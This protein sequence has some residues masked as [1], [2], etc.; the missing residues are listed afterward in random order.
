MHHQLT[1]HETVGGIQIQ[2]I[3]RY[4][5]LPRSWATHLAIKTPRELGFT[6]S[7]DSYIFHNSKTPNIVAFRAKAESAPR[8]GVVGSR[9]IF[10]KALSGKITEVECESSDTI[11]MV[12]N[13][14][15]D[16][17]GVP[18]DLHRLVFRGKNLENHLSLSY[19]NIQRGHTL[20]LLR[21]WRGGG[22]SP[23]LMSLGAGGSIK[24]TII[25]DKTHYRNWDVDSAKT[26]HLQVV[27]AAHF[28]ELTGI[29]APDTPIT[30]EQ[31]ASR[32]LP[33]F[34]IYNE[35]PSP[36][37][38]NFGGLKTVAE[39]DIMSQP[40]MSNRWGSSGSCPLNKCRCNVNLLDCMYVLQ[41]KA[42]FIS[43]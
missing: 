2:V 5:G 26:F 42:V 37:H 8:R 17:D 41:S 34:D 9:G 14:I 29:I 36:I 11:E 24:Q 20:Y 12:K 40:K 19:Y 7:E 25:V 35:R 22:Q 3:P 23:V 4:P 13:M 30:M 43:D 1:G 39:L 6:P 32:G 27:N 15:Q 38:G 21:N 10:I 16:I 33:F 31:Y 28:E 18:P